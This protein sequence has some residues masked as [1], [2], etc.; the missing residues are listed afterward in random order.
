MY[1]QLVWEKVSR[2]YSTAFDTPGT[3]GIFP[4]GGPPFLP[5]DPLGAQIRWPAPIMSIVPEFYLPKRRKGEDGEEVKAAAELPKY[6]E[7]PDD[8]HV[9]AAHPLLPEKLHDWV[10]EAPK[11]GIDGMIMVGL[12]KFKDKYRIVLNGGGVMP[13][14]GLRVSEKWG[15]SSFDLY[16][17][18]YEERRGMNA[19]NDWVRAKFLKQENFDPKLKPSKEQMESNHVPL[20]SSDGTIKIKVDPKAPAVFRRY[21]QEGAVEDL[22]L[23]GGKPWNRCVIEIKMFYTKGMASGVS[24]RLVFLRVDPDAVASAPVAKETV[25]YDT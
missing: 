10:T 8:I 14:D 20:M 21:R 7:H 23:L 22:A 6:G 12:G 13:A 5:R 24:S 2:A 18:D 3:C 4:E 17:R 19:F 1:W 15:G 11:G 25:D 16:V 9:E